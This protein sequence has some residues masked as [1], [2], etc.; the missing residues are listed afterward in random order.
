M[1]NVFLVGS[2]LFWLDIKKEEE[3]KQNKNDK[4]GSIKTGQKAKRMS[5]WIS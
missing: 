2:I 3:R 1:T 5:A 4:S